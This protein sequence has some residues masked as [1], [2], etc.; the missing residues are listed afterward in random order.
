MVN[1]DLVNVNSGPFMK[2]SHVFGHWNKLYGFFVGIDFLL[3]IDHF[4]LMI[5]LF[6]VIDFFLMID[7]FLVIDLFFTIDLFLCRETHN[8]NYF[9]VMDF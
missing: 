7:F 8:P 4:A 3:V 5:E 2:Y 9:I 1:L 6:V